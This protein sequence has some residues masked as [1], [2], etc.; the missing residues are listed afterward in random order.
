M[1]G[2]TMGTTY[3][4]KDSLHRAAML[5]ESTEGLVTV[6]YAQ[7]EVIAVIHA[8][9]NED[10]SLL[11][12]ASV[13]GQGVFPVTLQH[14]KHTKSTL[15]LRVSS[16]TATNNVAAIVL[17]KFQNPVKMIKVI[18]FGSGFSVETINM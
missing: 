4:T 7:G 15:L 5:E 16:R 3:V 13:G 14:K 8:P 6:E 11:T 18:R 1:N 2:D 9:K 17:D 12:C 10:F